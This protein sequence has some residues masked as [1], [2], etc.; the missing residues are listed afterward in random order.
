MSFKDKEDEDAIIEWRDY[1]GFNQLTKVNRPPLCVSYCYRPDGFRHSK[2][3]SNPF[4]GTSKTTVHHWDGQN[5]V[6]ET[7]DGKVQ[8]KYLRGINLIALQDGGELRYYLFN[9]HGD[10]VR[11]T[12][13][14]GAVVKEYDYDAFG[15]LQGNGKD[16]EDTNPFRY[17]GEYWDAETGTIYLRARYYNPR[18]GRFTQEDLVGAGLNWYTY[19]ENN[20]VNRI[21]PWGLDSYILYDPKM[22]L[23][24]VDNHMNQIALGLKDQYGTDVHT[25]TA[26][27]WTADSFETWWNG[28][29]GNIDAIV[30]A[31]HGTWDRIQFDSKNDIGR[32]DPNADYGMTT[33]QMSGLKVKDMDMLLLLGCNTGHL[34]KDSIGK[35]FA[36]YVGKGGRVVAPDGEVKWFPAHLTRKNLFP[37]SITTEY[38]TTANIKVVGEKS[39]QGFRPS[40]SNR[41]PAGFVVY[42]NQNGI[43]YSQDILRASSYSNIRN[44]FNAI[45]KS[46]R[47]YININWIDGRA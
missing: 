13:K 20:P 40:G 33:G 36:S 26:E 9:L 14:S 16:K 39:F 21:D 4:S 43:T 41:K 37:G 28:L 24:S 38:D 8:N 1:N 6:K 44:V 35:S 17:C 34:D 11:L 27:N 29:S 42:Y 32:D 7:V 19:C 5:I 3:V 30:I 2:S 15:N 45:Y 46:S 10:V 47:P 25:I 23:F 12:D 22:H 31:A 18:I